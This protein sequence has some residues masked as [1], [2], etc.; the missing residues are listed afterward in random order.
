MPGASTRT[1][2]KRVGSEVSDRDGVDS[3]RGQSVFRAI[4][5]KER[6]KKPWDATM[7]V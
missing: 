6:G 4:V 3:R 5:P 2:G 1:C 7:A